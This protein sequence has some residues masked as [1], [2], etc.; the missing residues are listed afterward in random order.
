MKNKDYIEINNTIISDLVKILE[1]K[2]SEI[3]FGTCSLILTYHCGQITKTEVQTA[4]A[5]KIER[6]Q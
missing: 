6:K 2:S 3:E 5:V 4:E 1:K